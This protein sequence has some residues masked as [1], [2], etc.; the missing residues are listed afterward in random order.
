MKPNKNLGRNAA[1]MATVK[2]YISSLWDVSF[3]LNQQYI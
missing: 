3:L 1:V 2:F